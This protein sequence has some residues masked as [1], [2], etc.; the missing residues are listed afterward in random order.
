MNNLVVTDEKTKALAVAAAEEGYHDRIL[1]FAKGLYSIGDDAVPEGARYIAHPDNW[2]RGWVKFVD[3]RPVEQRVGRVVDGFKVPE[4]DELGDTDETAWPEEDGRR[5]DPW[6]FQ[7]YLPLVDEKTNEMV[8]FVS[9]SA[10]GR[11]AIA[12]VCKAASQNPDNG[13]PV[14]MLGVGSYRHKTYGRIEE[15]EFKVVGWTGAAP[16]APEPV[17]ADFSDDVP[18]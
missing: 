14:V 10:G 9:G 4:R 12:G 1:K 13:L 17:V 16:T 2:V 3:R 6:A 15:P 8:V 7:S 5:R 18:F 11:R